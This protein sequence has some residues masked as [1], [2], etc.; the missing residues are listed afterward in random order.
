MIK[1]GAWH[2]TDLCNLNNNLF[3]N[4]EAGIGDEALLGT[5]EL[6]LRAKK[7]GV[8]IEI[9]NLDKIHDYDIILC[10]D[11]FWKNKSL[12]KKV[13]GR[14]LEVYQKLKNFKGHKYLILHECEVVHE[15]NWNK[16]NHFIF[17]KIFTW[18][19]DY[20]DDKRYFKLNCA[21]RQI[22][23]CSERFVSS[24]KKF[25][26]M[27]CSNIVNSRSNELYSFRRKIIEHACQF[28]PSSF[29]LY[30]KGWDQFSLDRKYLIGRLF[31]KASSK[32][33]IIRVK[34]SRYSDVYRGVLLTKEFGIRDYKFHFCLENAQSYPG[35]V[36]EK[37]FDAMRYGSIPVYL[38]APNISDLIPEGCFVD[39]KKFSGID[40]LFNFLSEMSDAERHRYLS[41]IDEFLSSEKRYPFSVDCYVSTLIGHFVN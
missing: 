20:V 11:V 36:T 10:F 12:I 29:D 22:N 18:A 16:E 26:S 17:D 9:L 8:Q 1:I 5:V 27:I 37:I 24:P 28:Y 38:G 40:H 39:I 14:H 41:N 35:Y 32:L 3:R 21:P 13:M 25:A 4:T 15:Q 33:E 30:G 34:N 23:H 7:L 31:N 19:D 2:Y 6:A